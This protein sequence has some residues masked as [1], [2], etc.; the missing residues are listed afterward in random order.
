MESLISGVFRKYLVDAVGEDNTSSYFDALKQDAVCSVRFNPFKQNAAGYDSHGFLPLKECVPWSLNGRYLEQRVLFPA[1]PLWHSGVYYVQDSS[2][3]IV[4]EVF[5]YLLR[6]VLMYKSSV[7][8]LDL[9]AAPGGKT[10]DLSARLRLCAGDDFL[11]VANEAVKQ[12]ASVL[13]ENVARW[14]DPNVI[15]TNLDPVTVG[16]IT[17]FFDIVLADVPC[18]GEG[19]FRKDEGAVRMWSEDNVKFCSARQKRIISDVLPSLKPGGYLLYSTCTFNRIENDDNLFFFEKELNCDCI[20][21]PVRHEGI[22]R[23]EKG[24]CLVPGLVPGEGQYC[25]VVQKKQEDT[26]ENYRH[27]RQKM[28]EKP[29]VKIKKMINELLDGDFLPKSSGDKVFAYPASSADEMAFFERFRPLSSGLA[30][31]RIKGNDFVPDAD[32]A[33]SIK[34]KKNHFVTK[35]LDYSRAI[36]FLK[37]EN[38]IL[39]D[40][41]KGIVLLCHENIPLGFVKNIGNRTNNLLPLSRRLRMNI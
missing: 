3:M 40:T 5:E 27:D 19:M 22:V 21:I 35:E 7:R 32:L 38:I 18:S 16:K 34:L 17:S 31:G 36:S 12:R 14:G 30:V 26:G 9:C 2:S 23:T 28:V 41:E 37:R 33:L 25:G 13:A 4:G 15:V 8:V 29:D 20:D 11:L 6:K 39:E 1:D 24:I 10:T